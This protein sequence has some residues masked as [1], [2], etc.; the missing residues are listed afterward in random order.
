MQSQNGVEGRQPSYRFAFVC[1]FC[2][3][4]NLCANAIKHPC[5]GE[6]AILSAF[7]LIIKSSAFEPH[8]SLCG[9]QARMPESE[10][11]K[12]IRTMRHR[13]FTKV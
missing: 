3:V 11:P 9:R 7:R 12:R 1:G 6:G 2:I 10:R 4:Q 13:A 8:F 5:L